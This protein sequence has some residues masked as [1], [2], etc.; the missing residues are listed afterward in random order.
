MILQLE[1]RVGSQETELFSVLNSVNDRPVT[2]SRP[3]PL[4][5]PQFPLCKMGDEY[6]L[7]L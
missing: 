4:T 7:F 2:L 5:G 6:Y 3:L 1:D